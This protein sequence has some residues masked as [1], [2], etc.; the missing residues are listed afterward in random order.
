MDVPQALGAGDHVSIA[1]SSAALDRRILGSAR[2]ALVVFMLDLS[3]GD[4]NG[5]VINRVW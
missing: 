5:S 3:L 4:Q 2:L 1:G